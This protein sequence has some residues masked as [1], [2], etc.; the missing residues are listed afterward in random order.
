MTPDSNMNLNQSTH[1]QDKMRKGKNNNIFSSDLSQL[2][3]TANSYNMSELI[4]DTS[5]SHQ[6]GVNHINVIDN[7]RQMNSVTNGNGHYIG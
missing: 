4:N 7:D 6:S 1:I 5:P 3:V 2:P